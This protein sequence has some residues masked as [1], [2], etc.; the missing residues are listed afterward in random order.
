MPIL[1]PFEAFARDAAALNVEEDESRLPVRWLAAAQV[2]T[3]LADSRPQDR[4]S[5][6]RIWVL[7]QAADGADGVWSALAVPGIPVRDL[8]SAAAALCSIAA[9]MER[10]AALNLAYSTVTHTR[11]A[12]MERGPAGARGLATFQQARVLREMGLLEEASDTYQAAREDAIRAK[13]AELEART[14]IGESGLHGHRGNYPAVIACSKR[15]LDLLTPTSEYRAL[16]HNDLMIAAMAAKD[17]RLAF[18]HGWKAFDAAASDAERRAAAVS[19]LASLA[20]RTGRFAEARRGYLCV[21]GMTELERIV[22][23]TLGGLSLLSAATRDVAELRRVAA[24]IKLRSAIG[25]Q[26][27]EIA[28]VRLELAQAW[29]ELGELE[30]ADQCLASARDLAAAHGFHE[31]RFRSELLGEAIAAARAN[32][33]D[34]GLSVSVARFSDLP[35]DAAV[36]APA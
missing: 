25:R 19:N 27:Y 28:R 18:E 24:T 8:A 2:A 9:D 7:Q 11:I 26:P 20:L 22:L 10:G 29:E 36:L 16:A 3:R 4:K 30:E 32:V 12:L 35:A 15:A 23:P 17:F 1:A 6:L 13:D 34:A 31:V 21:L 33:H 14:Y 5:L